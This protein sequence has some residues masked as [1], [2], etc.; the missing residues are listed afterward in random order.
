MFKGKTLDQLAAEY[1]LNNPTHDVYYYFN[2]YEEM[3]RR[4]GIHNADKCIAKMRK[5]TAL[6]GQ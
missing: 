5:V 2:L 3:C 1:A 4:V 6:L